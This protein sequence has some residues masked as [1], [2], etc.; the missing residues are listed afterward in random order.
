MTTILAYQGN[1]FAV[2]GTDSR[3]SSFDDGGMVYQIT[4]LGS[5]AAKVAENGEYLI[6]VAGDVRAINIVHHAFSPPVASRTVKDKKLDIFMTKSFVPSLRSCFEEQGYA[7]PEK[8]GQQHRAEQASSVLV[9]IHGTVYV[10]ESDYGW[11]SDQS[12]MYAIGTGSAYALG[13]LEALVGR[14][15]LSVEQAKSFVTKA[16]GIAA[17]FDPFTGGPFKTFLQER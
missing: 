6:G 2:V 1:D 15:V 7:T 17:K 12:G 14:R 3:I 9:A 16:L 11:T 5:G 8:E 10:I 13:A 4:T